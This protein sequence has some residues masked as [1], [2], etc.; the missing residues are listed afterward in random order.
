M[1]DICHHLHRVYGTDLSPDTV[2]TVTDAVL[3]EVKD[4][5]VSTAARARSWPSHPS[6]AGSSTPPT[7]SRA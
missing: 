1:R 7:R 6:C 3:E 4:L 5:A 2:S